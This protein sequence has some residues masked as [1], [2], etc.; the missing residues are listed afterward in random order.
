[1]VRGY[2]PERL[3]VPLPDPGV[4]HL[5]VLP[6]QAD[7]K[8]LQRCRSVLPEQEIS[9]S[10]HFKFEQ[11]KESYL[12]SQ[13][14]LRILLSAYLGLEPEL[15]GIGRRSKGKPYLTEHPEFHF[16]ISNSGKWA[17]YGFSRSGEIGVDLECVRHLQDM[18]ELI[19]QSFTEK[20]A[21]YITRIDSEKSR[22]FFKF[23][24]VKE[25]YLKAVGEGMRIPPEGLELN[26]NNGVF[27]L[28]SVRGVQ[29]HQDW[30]FSDFEADEEHLGTIVH[31][32]E[33][34]VF[35]KQ[36]F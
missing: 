24:T 2:L 34:P 14:G 9:R 33:Q 19:R 29:E 17:V 12:V 20:E 23:W 3:S 27:K 6:L 15:V 30:I 36:N 5:W 13:G 16:N 31:Q 7:E 4:I 21:G 32:V 35:I 28:E 10:E 8:L 26:V 25:A 1:M 22:R 18:D 11:G